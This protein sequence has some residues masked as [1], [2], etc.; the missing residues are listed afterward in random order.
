MSAG[1]FNFQNWSGSR[2]LIAPQGKE[3]PLDF[4]PFPGGLHCWRDSR[5]C[6]RAQ[7][8]LW[9]AGLASVLFVDFALREAPWWYRAPS[10]SSPGRGFRNL[11]SQPTTGREGAICKWYGLSQ[12]LQTLLR[13]KPYIL[14]SIIHSVYGCM[15]VQLHRRAHVFQ[16]AHPLDPRG[17]K[18]TLAGIR[19]SA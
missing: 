16:H 18:A 3:F 15:L 17:T 11:N 14:A 5:G 6:M 7:V 12:V 4:G 13:R 8:W 9:K 1:P 19:V 10:L 2:F